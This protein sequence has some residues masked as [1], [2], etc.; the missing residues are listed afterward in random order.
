MKT[1]KKAI[2]PCRNNLFILLLFLGF[3]SIS[4]PLSA[5]RARMIV[6]S[7]IGGSDPDDQQ[8]LVHLLTMLNDVDL[9]GFIYQHAWVSFNKGNEVT[10][11]EKAL[12]AYAKVWKNLST[13]SAGF[14][15]VETLRQRVKHG[16]KDAAM[17]GVGE[18]KDSPGSELIIQVVDCKDARPVWITTWSG[19]NTLAQAL[20]KVRNTRTA[21]EVEQFVSKIRVYDILGQDDAGAWIVTEFP[22]LVYIR[23]KAVYG[24]APD[25][26]WTQK[27]VQS[28]GELGKEYPNRKWAT[29]GDT[30]AFLYLIDNG[31]N[32]PEHPD[33]GGWGG[34]FDLEKRAGI[35][36]MD[37]VVR[38]GLD[39]TKYDPYL[40]LGASSEGGNAIN[41]WKEDIYNDF[42]ARM[43]WSVTPA[44]DAANHHPRAVIGKDRSTRTI[45]KK[46]KAGSTLNLNAH[47]SSDPD[48]DTLSFQWIHYLEPSSYKGTLT[49]DGTRER[50]SLTIPSEAKEGD[51]IHL[52]LRVTDNRTPRLTH[53]RRV[54]VE[55]K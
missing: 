26:N 28:V 46:V 54:V 38:N 8:S 2:S 31:L 4:L 6:L 22:D 14:P 11:T 27:N 3:C 42:A 15:D 29:E 24:W 41:R 16:Q 30:P 35:R 45:H 44:F 13:H 20:W 49:F 52:I 18:G 33:W 36:S 40:M 47:R 51:T 9:E 23:N 43:K 32:S 7:D 39:E 1:F 37:W 17:A 21:K 34:R 5:E 19:M 10:V 25:D 12:D 55:V 50:L 48:G 53:Y